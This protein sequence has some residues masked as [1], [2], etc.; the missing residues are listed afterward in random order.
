MCE[1]VIHILQT[2]ASAN[3]SAQELAQ[4]LENICKAMPAVL[5]DECKS[6]IETYG[7][8]IIAILVREFDP[9]KTCELIKLCPKPQNV[10]FLMKPNQQTCGL[11]DY[12]STY[13]SAGYPIGNVCTYFT[14]NQNVR[15]QCEVLVQL[16]K[17]N[18]CS[19]LPL[20]F[21]DVVLQ[22]LEEPTEKITTSP[23]CALCRYVVSY[24]DAVIQNNKSAAAIEAA[25]EK[26]CT[27]LPAALKPKCVTFV[28]TYGPILL[29]LIEKYATPAQVCN[30]L[31][32]CNNGTQELV[33]REY[34]L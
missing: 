13:L 16:Y 6:F 28:D 20:C 33:S 3:S 12:V 32:A 23:E 18:F 4:I 21:D 15:Q 25:L 30:A 26:V 27:I 34:K 1:F 8:D 2:F 24:V 19:Q 17:P 29:Q 14:T 22:P 7:N 9:A 31:K 10:A 11:C 5:R